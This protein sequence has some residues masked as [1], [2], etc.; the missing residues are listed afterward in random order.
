M[1]STSTTSG[2]Q[3]PAKSFQVPLEDL[4]DA[5]THL[6]EALRMRNQ[7]MERIGNQFPVTTKRFL[8]GEYPANLPKYRR[9]NTESSESLRSYAA[10]VPRVLQFDP[11]GGVLLVEL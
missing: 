7:Y 8:S 9:K 11:T 4:K 2:W 5:A 3:L 6:I 10:F 1:Q